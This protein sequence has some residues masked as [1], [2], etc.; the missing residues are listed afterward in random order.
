[1][2]PGQARP[3][4]ALRA[5]VP[6]DRRGLFRPCARMSPGQARPVPALRADVP[7][8]GAA[9]S[10]PARGCPP[11]QAQRRP[12][13][14]GAANAQTSEKNKRGSS[15]DEPRLYQGDDI[16]RPDLSVGRVPEGNGPR[17]RTAADHMGRRPSRRD[18][19]VPAGILSMMLKRR[20]RLY[21]NAGT[22]CKHIHAWENRSQSLLRAG[23]SGDILYSSA[24][25]NGT[26]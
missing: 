5:A 14:G 6:S 18:A 12:S 13:A 7:R 3:V 10:G 17:R 21:R 11:G 26:P 19:G 15:C 4:P 16:T 2:S 23:C 24:C 20:A 22:A 9:C 25:A 8:T 1:M